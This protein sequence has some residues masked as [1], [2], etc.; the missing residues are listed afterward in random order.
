[1]CVGP[2]CAPSDLSGEA[3]HP[4]GTLWRTDW[5]VGQPSMDDGGEPRTWKGPCC[6]GR[7]AGGNRTLS[8]WRARSGRCGVQALQGPVGT[9]GL[10]SREVLSEKDSDK[11]G[12]G[13]EEDW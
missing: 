1:M 8:K 4:A 9:K 11:K 2:G 7:G 13:K 10:W 3:R 12:Q 6:P 5:A